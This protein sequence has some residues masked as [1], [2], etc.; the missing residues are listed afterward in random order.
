[1]GTLLTF[2]K[3]PLFWIILIFSLIGIST[4]Y[5]RLNLS[6]TTYD[7]F[8]EARNTTYNETY[9]IIWDSYIPDIGRTLS[10]SDINEYEKFLRFAFGT[11][12]YKYTDQIA[13]GQGRSYLIEKGNEINARMGMTIRL[14]T[15]LSPYLF[16]LN[17]NIFCTRATSI[18]SKL[19]PKV[20]TRKL[21]S[22][23]YEIE[24][25][26][27]ITNTRTG[28]KLTRLEYLGA[29]PINPNYASP[30]IWSENKLVGVNY[31]PKNFPWRLFWKNFDHLELE[32]DFKRMDYIGANSIRIFLDYEIFHNMKTKA[33]ALDH[34]QQFLDLCELH[35]V[36]VI[37]TLFDIGF[38]YNPLNWPSA[39]AH[40]DSIL[41]KIS[42]HPALILVDIKNEP[43][44]DDKYYSSAII[45]GFLET[46]ITLIRANYPDL[47]VT[48]GWS[49]AS[50]ALRL[51]EMT[52]I[53]TY[54][55]FTTD[56]LEENFSTIRKEAHGKPIMITEVGFSRWSPLDQ[57]KALFLFT[58][59][60]QDIAAKHQ[61]E[62]MSQ[63]LTLA[64]KSDGILVWTLND[65]QTIPN[66]V[67]GWQPWRKKMQMN[68]GLFDSQ[69]RPYP[70][71]NI[72]RQYT[73][74]D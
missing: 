74:P 10:N 31:Y 59:Q 39:W 22:G 32:N 40:A 6:N 58:D 21:I 11:R 34:L 71:A 29:R 46:M 24:E 1:M 68:Y 8:H 37:I 42:S 53:I 55:I 14:Q 60:Q 13:S 73:Y 51:S 28:M 30:I 66:Y 2:Y 23:L 3:R 62:K 69:G 52:D 57:L 38:D 9:K 49:D 43:D 15:R 20:T 33:E 45:N 56:N 61:A 63:T 27:C 19:S 41:N 7:Y 26:I 5:I 64:S 16:H 44:R 48:I 12:A 72:I 25:F 65:F 70:A 67:A 18:M 4:I 36:K 17:K 47:A 50:Q 35:N 54:H